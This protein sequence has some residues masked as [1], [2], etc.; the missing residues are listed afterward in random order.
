MAHGTCSVKKTKIPVT[1]LVFE[2]F[3][4]DYYTYSFELGFRLGFGLGLGLGLRLGLGRRVSFFR[5]YLKLSARTE[6]AQSLFLV[7]KG[8]TKL[9]PICQKLIRP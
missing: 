4:F 2:N 3:Y 1:S 7:F 6:R 9:Q 5:L 8:F